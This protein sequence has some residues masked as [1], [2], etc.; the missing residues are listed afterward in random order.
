MDYR[1]SVVI[2]CSANK[3]RV[4]D[5]GHWFANIK[6]GFHVV[7]LPIKQPIQYMVHQFVITFEQ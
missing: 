1:Q 4:C 7:E 5:I 6:P 2:K 3:Q